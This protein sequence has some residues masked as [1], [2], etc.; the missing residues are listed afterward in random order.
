MGFPVE[1][2]VKLTDW[3]TWMEVLSAEKSAL[4]S[5]RQPAP[6]VAKMESPAAL[7]A[8]NSVD[9]AR[10]AARQ[11]EVDYQELEAILDPLSAVDK[12]SFVLPKAARFQS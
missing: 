5:S 7:T 8:A 9:A 1:R 6:G 10:K 4:G 11:G 3:P 2:S 12:K